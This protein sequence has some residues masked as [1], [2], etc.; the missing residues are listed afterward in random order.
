M[1]LCLCVCAKPRSAEAVGGISALETQPDSGKHLRLHETKFVP[2]TYTKTTHR[3]RY[4][5]CHLNPILVWV[6]LFGLLAAQQFNR[7]RNNADS[8]NKASQSCAKQTNPGVI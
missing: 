8:R 7:K 2:G 6:R 4:M 3:G 5:V 1:F